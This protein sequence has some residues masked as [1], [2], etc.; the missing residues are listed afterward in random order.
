ADQLRENGVVK[1]GLLGVGIENV[2]QKMAD[3]MDM[4]IPRGAL[5]NQ[6]S[7]DSAADKAGIEV[8]DVIIRF[9]NQDIT[10]AETLPPIVGMVQPNTKVNI[11]FFRDGKIKRLSAELDALDESVVSVDSSAD[12]GVKAGIGF[13][14]SKLSEQDKSR[15]GE[16]KGVIVTDI[17]D[18]EVQRAQ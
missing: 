1:R 4:K 8:G 10:T 5:V 3:Y 7:E 2:T 15:T 16:E 17:S 14:V 18:R 11:E 12:N 6:V 9:N 13:S